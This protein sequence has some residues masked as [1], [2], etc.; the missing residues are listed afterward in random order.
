MASKSIPVS[1]A[2]PGMITAKD[3]SDSN[4]RILIHAGS[5]L[6]PVAIRRLPL[7]EI[8]NIFIESSSVNDSQNDLDML[9]LPKAIKEEL[10]TNTNTAVISEIATKVKKRFKGIDQDEFYKT[11]MNVLLKYLVNNNNNGNGII[12]GSF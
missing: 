1:D 9:V 4:G 8:D 12:S 5:R 2:L 11:Y 10:N 6:S 7:W 3:I